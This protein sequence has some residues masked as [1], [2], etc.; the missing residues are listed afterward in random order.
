MNAHAPATSSFRNA[1]TGSAVSGGA[2]KNGSVNGDR[3]R[4]RHKAKNGVPQPSS[5]FHR[6]ESPRSTVSDR[7]TYQG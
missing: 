3:H 7:N 5:G 2:K 4:D 6:S 1:E